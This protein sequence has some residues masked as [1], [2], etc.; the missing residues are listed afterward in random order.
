VLLAVPALRALRARDPGE[1]LTLA[2]Q[3]RLAALLARLGVVDQGISFE[4]LGL[5]SLFVE[6]SAP[7]CP[8]ISGARRVVCWFGAHEPVFSRRL[9]SLAPGALVAAAA[10]AG[11]PVWEHLLATT[12]VRDGAWCEP[13]AAPACLVEESRRL[14]LDLG[15]DG[16]RRL[17]VVH[18][19]AGGRAKQWPVE[20]FAGVLRAIAA[21][22]PVAT[23]VHQG[24][25]DADA[26]TALLERL[27]GG[28]MGLREP[29]LHLLG[30]VLAQATAYLGNDSGVSHL[31]GTLGTPS[32]VLFTPALRDWRPWSSAARVLEV[33]TA[34]LTANDLEAA[35]VAL[36]GA[37]R[38][39]RG[40][41]AGDR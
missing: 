20:G 26:A 4:G 8:P 25:A 21:R 17:L 29:A 2:A 32:V 15:W 34:R 36:A 30:G 11:T 10:A 19:G 31:A 27:D 13:V 38:T 18:P 22:E 16:S 24:P 40:G 39:A 35:T 5:A 9:R 33:V 23:V 12:G 28:A 7:A 3:P 14:L 37:L 41:A 1:P 6:E